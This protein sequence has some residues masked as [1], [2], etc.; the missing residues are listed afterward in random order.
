MAKTIKPISF[1]DKR[2]DEAEMLKHI[3][4]RNFSGYVK[5]LIWEDMQRKG[6]LSSNLTPAE[7]STPLLEE[8]KPISAGERLERL[9][10]PKP[11]LRFKPPTN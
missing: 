3:K 6:A 2:S 10:I 7:E 4:R 1:N 11:P 8:T 5:K 9:K